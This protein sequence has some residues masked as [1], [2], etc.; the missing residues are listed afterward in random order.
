MKYKPPGVLVAAGQSG[1]NEHGYPLHACN[2]WRHDEH[3]WAY[4]KHRASIRGLHG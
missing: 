3:Y 2:G 4:M 1:H